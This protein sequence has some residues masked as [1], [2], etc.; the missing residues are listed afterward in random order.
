MD[1]KLQFAADRCADGAD[2]VERQLSL[3]DQPRKAQGFQFA[4]TFGRANGRLRG[5]V[6]FHGRQLLFEQAQVLDNENVDTRIGE[7]PHQRKGLRALL[8]REQGVDGCVNF[9]AVAV[10]VAA[11]AGDVIDRIA[12]CRPGAERG[13]GNINGIG[14]AVD[15]CDADIRISRR[16][17]QFKRDYLH[18][19]C[20]IW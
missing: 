12:G 3:Q 9:R 2:L 5:C 19:S 11:K 10:G 13:P 14:T 8:F 20:V 6:E 16:S 15:R 17:E 1:E 4:C 18:L 7:F